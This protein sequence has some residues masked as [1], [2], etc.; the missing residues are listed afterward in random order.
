[1]EIEEW[2]ATNAVTET[3]ANG[4]ASGGPYEAG[5]EINMFRAR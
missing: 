1:M 5:K 2:K 4:L 3:W